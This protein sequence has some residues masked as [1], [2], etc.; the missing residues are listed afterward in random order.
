MSTVS[1]KLKARRQMLNLSMQNV[2]AITG[3]TNSKL[4]RYENNTVCPAADLGM[5]ADCYGMDKV[6]LF[7]DAG[8]LSADDV[9]H[10]QRIFRGADLLNSCECNAVQRIIDLLNKK[11]EAQ[12]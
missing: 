1:M 8:Y 12:P 7:I 6:A 5:L 11:K 4:C 2:Q 9:R 10:Y 3:I